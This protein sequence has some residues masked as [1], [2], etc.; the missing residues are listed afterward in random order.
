LSNNYHEEARWPRQPMVAIARP[1]NLAS[2]VGFL[3]L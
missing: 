1:S 2:P 3:E